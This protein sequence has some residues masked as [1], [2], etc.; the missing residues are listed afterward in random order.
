[1]GWLQRFWY[2]NNNPLKYLLYPFH[3]LLNL[4]IKT[5]IFFYKAGILKSIRV[6]VPVIIVG[7]IT[8][9][10]TGK[11]PLVIYLAEQF[12]AL[13][14][15]VGVLSR[16]YGGRAKQYPMEVHQNSEIS[17]VGDEPLM[18][19]QRT[20]VKVVV[21]PQRSRGAQYLIDSHQCDLILCD[22]GLQHYAL[23][24][25]IELLLV[26]G[27]RKY[28]NALLLP[29]GPLREPVSR[30]K[31]VNAVILNQLTNEI[32]VNNKNVFSMDLISDCFISVSNSK[33]E[34]TLDDLL[35]K[36]R[37]QQCNVHAVAGIGNP[38][39]FFNQIQ[40]LGFD[41]I[42]HEF[43][44][45]HQFVLNDFNSMD[46]I[47]IMTEKD[48]VKCHSFV[49]EDVW[50]L[51]VVADVNPSITHFCTEILNTPSKH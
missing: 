20:H 11:S 21:D 19:K 45:H 10:G 49:S 7:N 26:D 3:I 48:A 41:C 2:Q 12:T 34:I 13:G 24:R 25:D 17:V 22:D 30:T 43:D 38:Q 9:G 5:R 47:I 40:S 4:F 1:M 27:H 6:N 8:V 50:Y 32:D 39:R 33:I 28:G 35:T 51:K 15:N 14:L 42:T 46:G 37:E 31:T 16:G 29:F 23:E 44:D 36:S 18:I